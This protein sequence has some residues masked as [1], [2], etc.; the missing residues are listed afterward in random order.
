M[1]IVLLNRQIHCLILLSYLFIIGRSTPD[2][3]LWN[4]SSQSVSVHLSVRP[5]VRLSLNF[6]KIGSLD[7]PDIVQIDSWL[8]NIS[9]YKA[10]ILKKNDRSTEFGTNGH[11][12]GQ[13][14]FLCHFLEFGSYVFFEIAY[15]DSPRQC[16]TSSGRKTH[17]KSL[18]VQIWVTWTKIGAEISFFGHFLRFGLLVFFYI[19]DN[20]NKIVAQI[21]A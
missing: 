18:G 16:L 5:F 11:K 13:N 20:S 10:R 6:L 17:E 12:L 14:V 8:W 2:S 15:D 7:F 19:S 1:G 3:I 4:H 21:R 9:T